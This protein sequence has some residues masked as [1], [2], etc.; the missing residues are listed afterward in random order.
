MQFAA[1]VGDA[2]VLLVKSTGETVQLTVD[3]VPDDENERRRI[4]SFNP[5]PKLPLV[6]FKAGTWRVGGLLALSRAFGD[7]YLKGSLNA[8]GFSTGQD[9]SMGYSSGF[10]L[11][12]SPYT[13]LNDLTSEDAWI[14]VSSDGL[15]S[16]EA[17]GGGGGLDSRSLAELLL[18]VDKS[19]PCDTV[20]SI[21][22]STAVNLGS[23]D[24]VT[25]I[26]MRLGAAS[27]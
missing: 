1:N 12:A 23:T 6:Q 7:A 17:R 18:S 20:A 22:A 4:Q 25:V 19:V 16:E 24:D 14:V 8:E 10:G 13:T 11:I 27:G 26:V 5:N 3:H 9:R 15:Y 21:L 2:R